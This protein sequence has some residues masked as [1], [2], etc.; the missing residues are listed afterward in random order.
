[1][2]VIY[3]SIKVNGKVYTLSPFDAIPPHWISPSGSLGTFNTQSPINIKLLAGKAKTYIRRSGS[4]PSGLTLDRYNGSITGNTNDLGTYTFSVQITNNFGYVS[5]E[6][7]I[8][9]SS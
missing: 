7:S 4:L 3:R 1:M 8:T 5:Q 6:F 9:I 2:S